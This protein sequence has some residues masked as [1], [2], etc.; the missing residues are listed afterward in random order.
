MRD[1]ILTDGERFVFLLIEAGFSEEGKRLNSD[2][3]E[4]IRIIS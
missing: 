2:C 4:K 3:D 1:Y